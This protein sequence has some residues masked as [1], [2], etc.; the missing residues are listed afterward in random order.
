MPEPE[1]VLIIQEVQCSK[2]NEQIEES[3]EKCSKLFRSLKSPCLELAALCMMT[4]TLMT[5]L[6]FQ[7][8]FMLNI[9][10]VTK[11]YSSSVCHEIVNNV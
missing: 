8:L 6:I 1:E 4:S 10:L 11:N 5:F 9:C 3:D 2:N 7:N